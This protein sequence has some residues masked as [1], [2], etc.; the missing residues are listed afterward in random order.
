MSNNI[1]ENVYLNVE[2]KTILILGKRLFVEIIFTNIPKFLFKP[3][4][5]DF[6]LK[7]NFNWNFQ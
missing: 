3:R 6:I 7:I 5:Y 1:A 4:I 2:F